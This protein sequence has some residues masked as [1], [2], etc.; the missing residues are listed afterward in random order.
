M[1]IDFHIRNF[2]SIKEEQILNF[3]ADLKDEKYNDYFVIKAGKH[4]LLKLIALYGP[5]G[6]G[7]TT[8]LRAFDTLRNIVINTRD[9]NQN[10]NY[11]P[12]AFDPKF[13]KQNTSFKL[14]FLI[15]EKNEYIKYRYEIEYNSKEIVF[16]KLSYFPST[17]AAV[18]YERKSNADHVRGF[19]FIVQKNMKLKK[20]EKDVIEANTLHNST[21][22]SSFN[23]ANP[24]FPNAK[25]VF[26][27]FKNY[28]GHFTETATFDTKSLNY[29]FGFDYSKSLSYFNDADRKKILI[30]FLEN[31]DMN[32]SDIVIPEYGETVSE[33]KDFWK[34]M[35]ESLTKS[36]VSEEVPKT[37]D[38]YLS[39]KAAADA[40][41]INS[42]ILHNYKSGDGNKATFLPIAF[43]SA[44]TIRSIGFAHK[45][46]QSMI[47]PSLLLIDEIENS[48]H[49][50]MVKY[51]ILTYLSN[52]ADSQLIFT[53]HNLLLMDWD[54]MRNDVI[55]FTEKKED[56]AT[57]LYALTDF[58]G[59]NRK[60]LLKQYMA[61]NLGAFPD[62]YQYKFDLEL[63]KEKTES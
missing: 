20:S 55:W 31:A 33:F 50:E 41:K 40:G 26:E 43:E 49:L 10:L 61:G 59:V 13:K 7:K 5:N 52:S 47:Q 23:K 29:L 60:K 44:G 36:C 22:L 37:E 34:T 19:D 45:L 14:D 38:L 9:A 48:L 53:T 3:E 57:D 11:V 46:A 1:I 24:I 15:K 2:F 16:E 62:I 32:I 51:S 6:S 42:K 21:I 25:K 63:V 35:A 54:I 12:F 4:N 30:Q 39:N 27:W 58:N 18:I 56:G 8:I 17:K 28:M